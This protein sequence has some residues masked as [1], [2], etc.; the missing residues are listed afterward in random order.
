MT[1]VT[2]ALEN[3]RNIM[4]MSRGWGLF[5]GPGPAWAK[6]IV[7]VG[8]IKHN[9]TSVG[10]YWTH[11]GPQ[12]WYL[13]GI[14]MATWLDGAF[15]L[16]KSPETRDDMLIRLEHGQ[17]VRFGAD[18]DQGVRRSPD[19]GGLEVCAGDDPAVIVHDAYAADPS[20]AFALSRLAEPGSLARS[21]IGVFRQV[22]R[23][24]YGDLMN[25]QLDKAVDSQGAGE[26]ASLLAG[27][28]PWTVG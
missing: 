3:A 25:A 24:T 19:T 5:T 9:G 10:G 17:P 6:N 27:S 12:G 8:G 11:I 20:T 28:D 23:A 15:D 13:D 16:L 2:K 14:L 1:P 7:S 4:E 22:Q 21:P 18:L 26:L